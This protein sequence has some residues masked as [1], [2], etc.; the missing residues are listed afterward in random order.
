MLAE[1]PALV[2]L[3]LRRLPADQRGVVRLWLLGQSLETIA[4][5]LGIMKREVQRRWERAK[6]DLRARLAALAA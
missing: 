3:A 2:A 4:Q 1:R 5:R 6:D